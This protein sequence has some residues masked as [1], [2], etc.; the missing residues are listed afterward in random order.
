MCGSSVVE[1]IEGATIEDYIAVASNDTVWDVN[2]CSAIVN[3]P[4]CFPKDLTGTRKEEG[5]DEEK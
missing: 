5:S 2:G 1:N 4:K 3:W